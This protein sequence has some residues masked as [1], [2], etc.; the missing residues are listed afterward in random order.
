MKKEVDS[1]KE[2]FLTHICRWLTRQT[3]DAYL[4]GDAQTALEW[5]RKLDKVIYQL[6]L[7]KNHDLLESGRT[8][9]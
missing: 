3:E 2:W 8:G 1:L 6:M 5:S 7:I 9:K 4:A